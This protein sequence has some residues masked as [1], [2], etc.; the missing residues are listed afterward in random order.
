MN[1]EL[2]DT[3]LALKELVHQF[4]RE[5]MLPLEPKALAREAAGQGFVLSPE[6]YAHLNERTQALG[7]WGLDAPEDTQKYI[8]YIYLWSRRSQ[9]RCSISVVEIE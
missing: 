4:V 8:F 3:H 6:E 5:E 2:E 1:F 9:N 7:L